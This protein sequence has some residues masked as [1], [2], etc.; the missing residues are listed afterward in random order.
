MS[1]VSDPTSMKEGNT[2]TVKLVADSLPAGM[3]GYDMVISMDNSSVAD[4]TGVSFPDWAVIKSTT[5]L[6]PGKI[7]INAVDLNSKVEAGA[8]KVLLATLT[9]KGNSIGNTSISLSKVRLDSDNGDS[10]N[11]ASHDSN[12]SV[13]AC[14]KHLSCLTMPCKRN[15]ITHNGMDFTNSQSR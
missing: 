11:I 2:K 4:I 12:L 13:S 1:V 8:D 9:V 6:S 14:A 7:R 15:N 10:I 3:S 5:E